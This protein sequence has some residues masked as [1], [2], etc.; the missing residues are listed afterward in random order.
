MISI[1]HVNG[2]LVSDGEGKASISVAVA[3]PI[4]VVTKHV[5]MFALILTL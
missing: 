5:F 3:A 4:G 2:G 1:I